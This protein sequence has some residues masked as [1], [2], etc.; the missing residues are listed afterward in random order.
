MKKIKSFTQ[1]ELF[2]VD[3][4]EKVERNPMTG[5]GTLPTKTPDIGLIPINIPYKQLD[6]I[7]KEKIDRFSAA[8]SAAFEKVEAN[9]EDRN[10]PVGCSPLPWHWEEGGGGSINVLD[11]N[12]NTVFDN[13]NGGEIY[14]DRD[15]ENIELMVACV[16]MFAASITADHLDR[17][18]RKQVYGDENYDE[19]AE[20]EK[21]RKALEE[22][23]KRELE[24][25]K[26]KYEAESE[27]IRK[28]GN[29]NV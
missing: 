23:K 10:N 19:D 15:W 22:K 9:H 27:A 4:L 5:V 7:T 14:S 24:E 1:A 21:A 8:L 2:G 28:K 26:A 12:N 11:A 3:E 25:A 6:P 17:L 13:I 29:S 16:N 18:R 20:I